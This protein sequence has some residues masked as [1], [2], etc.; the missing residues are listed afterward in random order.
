MAM[1]WSEVRIVIAGRSGQEHRGK[2]ELCEPVEENGLGVMLPTTIGL[3]LLI[4]GVIF[5]P[6][7]LLNLPI[8]FFRSALSEAFRASYDKLRLA[9]FDCP[10][11]GAPNP[12]I[13]LSGALPLDTPCAACRATL[14]VRRGPRRNLV[15]EGLLAP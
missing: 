5:P 10:E 1:R 7:L 9:T 4:F 14:S 6:C 15:E 8:L 12:P 11:C 3:G 13:E 2:G